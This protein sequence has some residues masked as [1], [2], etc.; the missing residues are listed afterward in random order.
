MYHN[1]VNFAVRRPVRIVSL[2]VILVVLALT[3]FFRIKVDTDPENMLPAKAP[4][5]V[6][7]A[8]TKKEFS[9]YD[10]IVWAS[11]TRKTPMGFLTR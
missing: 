9:L 8:Q 6:F 11:S 2:T 10:F 7:H 5:R 4:V 1:V 3:Q